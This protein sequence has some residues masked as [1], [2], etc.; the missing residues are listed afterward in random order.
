MVNFLS[1]CCPDLHKLL[2]PIDDLTRKGRQF[3]WG[4]EQQ[5]V[6]EEIKHRLVKLAVLHFARQ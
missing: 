6:F 5:I 3:M 2:K 4:K 1:T